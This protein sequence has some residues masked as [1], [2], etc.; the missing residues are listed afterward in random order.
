MR[1]LQILRWIEKL[2]FFQ[3]QTSNSMLLNSDERLTNHYPA[4]K[5][6][7]TCI[8]CTITHNLYFTFFIISL[9]YNSNVYHTERAVIQ[10]ILNKI[11][12]VLTNIWFLFVYVFSTLLIRKLHSF[13]IIYSWVH[14]TFFELIHEFLCEL[15]IVFNNI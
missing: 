1:T 15:L 13:Y 9:N 10:V 5:S 12:I 6:I 4:P 11:S 8:I 2:N 3:N 7:I 14:F